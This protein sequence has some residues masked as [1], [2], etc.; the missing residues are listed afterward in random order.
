MTNEP[1]VDMGLVLSLAKARQLEQ[2]TRVGGNI[3][4]YPEIVGIA[5][6][7]SIQPFRTVWLS[8]ASVKMTAKTPQELAAEYVKLGQ[9]IYK[10]K[11]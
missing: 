1:Q 3:A 11:D 2:V 8:D 9:P 4:D 7:T 5:V 6:T 10:A